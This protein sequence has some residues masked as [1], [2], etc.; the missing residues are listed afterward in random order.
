[1]WK[2]LQF[3]DRTLAVILGLSAHAQTLPAAS[4]TEQVNH[5][6]RPLDVSSGTKTGFTLLAPNQSGVQ[7]RNELDKEKSLQNQVY[8]NGSGVALGDVDGDGRCDIYLCGLDNPNQ[9][10][11]NK[12]NWKFEEA[13]NDYGA[14]CTGKDSTGAV[15]ADLDSDGDLDLIVNTVHSGTLLFRNSGARFSQVHGQAAELSGARG[16]MSLAVADVDADGRLDFYATYYRDTTLMDMPNTY[17]K[18]RT[19]GGRKVVSSVDGVPVEGSKYENR[20]RL[21]ESGGIEENGRPDVLYRN[22]GQFRFERNE[23]GGRRFLSANGSPLPGPLYEWGLSAMFRDVNRDGRP[24][25]YVCNDF[26]GHDRLWLNAGQGRFREAPILALRKTSMFSMGVDFADI[27]RDGLDDFLVM[28]MLNTSHRTQMNQMLPRL[29]YQPIPGRYNDRQQIMRNTLLLNR[30]YG[31]FSEIANYAGIAASDWSW[32]VIFMDVDLDGLEDVLITNGVERN[33]RHLDTIIKLRKQRENKKLSN[34]EIL[35]A[36]RVFPAQDTPNVAFRNLDGLRFEGSAADWGFD[37]KAVSH[38]MACGDLDGDGDLDVVVNNLRTPAGVYRNNAPK[39]RIAVRLSGPPGNTTGIGARIEL[40]HVGRTQSQEMIGGGRYLSSDDYVRVFALPEGSGRLKVIW[41]D[42]KETVVDQVE[43]NRVYWIRYEPTAAKPVASDSTTSVFKQLKFPS[44][45]R[46]VES[47][48]NEKQNQPLMPWTLGQ[49][50]PGAAWG[51]LDGDGWEDLIIGNGK[52]G[53]STRYRNKKG[54]GF[55]FDEFGIQ[56][57]A[58]PR[59]VLSILVDDG[60][61][62]QAFSNYDDGL[63]FG[64]MATISQPDGGAQQTIRAK[65]ASAGPMAMADID[66]DGDLDLFIGARAIPN[67]YPMSADS[68]IFLREKDSWNE[69]SKWSRA[70]QNVGLVAGVVFANINSDPLPDLLLACDWGTPKVFIN[71]GKGFVDRTEFY[72][73]AKF[74][75]FWR[76]IDTGDFNGDGRMDFVAAN[77]GSNSGCEASSGVPLVLYHGD[78]DEDGNREIIETERGADGRLFPKRT[79]ATINSAL[80]WLAEHLRS[81][82]HYAQMTI[83][84]LFIPLRLGNAQRVEITTLES[85]IFIQLDDHFEAKKLPAEAQFSSAFSP[86]VADFDNDG[87]ED[88]ALSQNAFGVHSEESRQD[89]GYGVL[90]LGDGTGAFV[91][92]DINESALAVFGEGRG[93]AAADFNH[94]GRTDL[95]VCQ[96]GAKPKL[97]LNQTKRRGIRIVLKGQEGNRH[98]VGAQLRLE[99]ESGLGASRTVRLGSGFLSQNSTTQVLGGTSPATALHVSWPNGEKERFVLNPKQREIIADKGAGKNLVN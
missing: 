75:G 53:A 92:A 6:W 16:G 83:D 50:G 9:L 60:K 5:K 90:L 8:L 58:S 38:G 96:N 63:A 7:F 33:A 37:T 79:L 54:K 26:D 51:D 43:P 97:Y 35:L 13:A 39:P 91:A 47:P 88:I 95:V 40:E 70:L 85:T 57:Q 76:G 28:D 68:W 24:D 25:I 98:G 59:E 30:G 46:H 44:A 89:A 80:P 72:G 49:D 2:R 73:L 17:F 56:T 71:T 11:L 34:R 82:D 48:S 45:K 20:F 14:D 66:G 41:P 74:T 61:L 29:Q 81:Y 78:L 62:V 84:E 1:M 67:N 99:T 36:R 93:A 27:N 10:Y 64:N 65:A 23:V 32:C 87:A 19:I 4:W 12:G 52:G 69:N 42:L 18:F 22:L 15:F 77:L 86:V 3:K 21:N 31:L 94:D 55:E